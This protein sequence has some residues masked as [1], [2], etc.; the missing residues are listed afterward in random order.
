[1]TGRDSE[2]WPTTATGCRHDAEVMNT[3]PVVPT[4]SDLAADPV[5]QAAEPRRPAQPGGRFRRIAATHPIL[6]LLGVAIPFVW[7]TQLGSALAGLDLMPAKLA[8]LLVLVGLAVAITWTTNGRA[9]VRRL[10]AGLL[11]WR[12]E[13]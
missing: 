7:L 6:L 5:S 4:R 3:S 10:F 11:R 13:R 2:E 1:M 9:G 12:R 8:E